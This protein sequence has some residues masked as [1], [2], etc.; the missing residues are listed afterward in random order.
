M[1]KN[2]QFLINWLHI[3]RKIYII[4]FINFYRLKSPDRLIHR[5]SYSLAFREGT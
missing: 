3:S 2:N 5:K 1:Y 4:F